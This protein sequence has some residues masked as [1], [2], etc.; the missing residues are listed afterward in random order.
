MYV[1]M[2]DINIDYNCYD[3]NANLKKYADEITCL[4][5]EQMVVSPTRISPSRQ[6]IL[7]H[8]YIE[9]SMHNEIISVGV[10]QFDIS[11]HHPTIIII[12]SKTQRKNIARPMVRKILTNKIEN[13]VEEL[14][15]NLQKHFR[16]DLTHKNI[17]EL[18]NCVKTVTDNIFPK[19]RV[20]R[21][22]FKIEKKLWIT[23]DIL[24]ALKHSNKL[25]SKYLN[26]NLIIKFIE[27]SEI[28]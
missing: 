23:K 12:K 14:D 22:Q 13:F 17:N 10:I 27:L 11:V 16:D 6:S 1:V 3:T 2:G 26:R 21:K 28:K 25:Y 4:E 18:I 20:S 5:C 19:T 15:K 7:D 24:K 9:N 8:I